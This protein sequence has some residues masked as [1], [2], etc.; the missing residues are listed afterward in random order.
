MEEPIIKT[1]QKILWPYE[2]STDWN[3]GHNSY[4]FV[5]I[6]K[7]NNLSQG[8]LL[9]LWK[10]LKHTE[11]VSEVR[12]GREAGSRIYR[13]YSGKRGHVDNFPPLEKVYDLFM[14]L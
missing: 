10:L 2:V 7:K 14:C 4:G 5:Q 13:R 9:S 12:K 6:R 1:S 11:I 8:K 3:K